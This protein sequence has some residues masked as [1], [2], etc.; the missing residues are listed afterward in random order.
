MPAWLVA[1]PSCDPGTVWPCTVHGASLSNPAHGSAADTGVVW[2]PEWKIAAYTVAPSG[3]T[4][5]PRGVSPNSVTTASA[6]PPSA[7][8]RL[9]GSNTQ[10]SARPMPAVVSCGSPAPGTPA[11][12]GLDRCWPRWAVAMNARPAPANTMSP[13]SSPTSS[14]RTTRGGACATS[15]MLTLSDTWL[16]TQT[17]P[18]LRTATAT[19]SIPTLPEPS[20]TSPAGV[21]RR[22]SSEPLGV[23]ATNTRAPSDD[24]ASGRTGPLSN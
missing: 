16:T 22:M 17:S 1:G 13:G 19:G 23:L 11:R 7:V 18:S 2:L 15:T 5:R 10:T 3:L 4:A 14:V 20:G 8:P 24:T 9:A 6:R 21:T 12:S